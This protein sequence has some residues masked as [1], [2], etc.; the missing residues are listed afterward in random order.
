MYLM[1]GSRPDIAF[2]VGRLARLCE[3][4]KTKHWFAVK[5]VLRC[6]N[7]TSKM[8]FC[9]DGLN[10]SDVFDCSDSEWAGDA[11]DRKPT[12][13][14]VFMMVGA[15]VSWCSRKQSMI[16]TSSCEAEYVA[17]CMTCKEAVWLKRLGSVIPLNGEQDKG[18]KVLVD[19]QSTIKLAANESTNRRN[20]QIDI[21]HHFLRDVTSNGEVLLGY[22]PT[23]NMMED[24]LNKP[25]GRVKVEKLRSM[26]GIGTVQN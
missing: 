26:C 22:I 18:M 11:S 4:P 9:Y 1:I 15:A 19:S 16:V 8:G 7:G 24:M 20:K 2:A 10:S 12:S 23:S 5:R 6:V 25:L 3:S 17:L 13:A 21:P 14:Y